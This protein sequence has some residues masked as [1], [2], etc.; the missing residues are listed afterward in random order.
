[1]PILAA[2][3][4]PENWQATDSKVTI[5]SLEAGEYREVVASPALPRLSSKKLNE[6]L[7]LGHD[8]TRLEWSEAVREWAVDVAAEQ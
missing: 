6:F 7:R 3:G 4:V 1:L 5:L 2:L 8:L